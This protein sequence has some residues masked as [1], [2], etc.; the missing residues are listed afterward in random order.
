[1]VQRER[2]SFSP[3]VLIK[4]AP[5][6][7]SPFPTALALSMESWRPRARGHLAVGLLEK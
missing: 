3:S 5:K 7:L 2:T 1:M 4:V 6:V